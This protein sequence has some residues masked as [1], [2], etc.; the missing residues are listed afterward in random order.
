[1]IA[2]MVYEQ[3]PK[4]QLALQD[5]LM[6]NLAGLPGQTEL[7]AFHVFSRRFERKMDRMVRK[8]RRRTAQVTASARHLKKRLILVGIILAIM[9]SAV[10][11]TL[12]RESV[13]KFIIDAYEKYSSLIFGDH[14]T[15]DT[16]LTEPKPYTEDD[17]NAIKPAWLPAGYKFEHQFIGLSVIQIAY[18]DEAGAEV[19]VERYEAGHLQLL[20]D[21]EGVTAE[22]IDL[23]GRQA[24]IYSK[25]GQQTLIWQDGSFAFVIS[26][27]ISRDA[28]LHMADSIR[29]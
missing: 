28:I 4:L 17:A 26:G 14:D 24:L 1:V 6:Q 23:D 21:T 29:H 12:A 13:V 9:L 3:S 25:N 15:T 8:A 27:P 18:A 10:S 5:Y 20:I 11:I 16:S 22:S 2:S 19:W 7:A